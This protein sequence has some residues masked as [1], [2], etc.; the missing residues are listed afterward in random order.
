MQYQFSDLYYDN[1]PDI[2]AFRY[3]FNFVLD[4]FKEADTFE[5]QSEALFSLKELRQD[6]D[7]QLFV[8]DVLYS[9]DTLDDAYYLQ[10]TT[11][12][13]QIKDIYHQLIISFYRELCNTKF[14][15]QLQNHWGKDLFAQAVFWL[16]LDEA[17]KV[18]QRIWETY[19]IPSHN[20]L[21]AVN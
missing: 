2:A 5:Q 3:E 14:K 18:A 11:F 9:Q 7:G 21:I 13:E 10:N 19:S 6:F 15:F 4:I 16:K 20:I 8:A 12:L 1:R 17:T